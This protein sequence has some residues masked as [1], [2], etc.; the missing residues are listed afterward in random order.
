M[1]RLARNL[2]HSRVKTPGMA[3]LLAATVASIALLQGCSGGSNAHYVPSTTSNPAPGVTLQAVTVAPAVSLISIGESRQLTAIATYSDGTTADVTSTVKWAS[4]STPAIAVSS[5]GMANATTFGSAAVSATLGSS[6]GL[7]QLNVVSNGF[8]S[9]TLAILPVPYKSGLIDA[10]YLPQSLNKIQGT[11]SVQ[12]VNLDADQFS[13]VLPVPS[14]LLASIP[15][16]SGFVPNITVASLTSALV[17]V[18]SYSSPE[19]LIIDASNNAAD[20]AN[21]SVIS[22]FKAPVSGSVTFNGLTCMI[23]AA[24]VN[25]LDNQLLMST[26]DGYFEMDLK[27]GTF[28]A[29]PFAG[30]L[31]SPSFTLNPLSTPP[32]I[33]SSTFGQ[34]PPSPPEV[35]ILD[36]ATN[37]VTSLTN[38]GVTQP[39]ATPIDL[40]V[41]ATAVM[42][43]GAADQSLLDLSNL[44]N[45]VSVL[46]TPLGS[47][48]APGPMGMGA[49][50][51]PPPTAPAFTLFMGQVS[52]SCFGFEEWTGDPTNSLNVQYGY[53]VMPATPDNKP[54]VNGS[55]P[56]TIATFNSV[57]DKKNY[58]V[59]VDANQNWIAKLNPL[60]ATGIGATLGFLP[61]G[62]LITSQDFGQ[63]ASQSIIY[64]PT[65]ASVVTLSQTNIN[66]GTQ[67]VG[68]QSAV[69][70]ITLTNVGLNPLIISQIAVEGA[71]AG[72]FAESDT[73]TANPTLSPLTNCTIQLIF[74][75]S[76]GGPRSATLS[77]TDNGGASPQV[78]LL[79]G[80]GM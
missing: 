62:S 33:V 55:D 29:L 60:V 59:L 79:S 66:F 39:Y 30:A 21:N 43:V 76:G 12:E 28:T 51:V 80:T 20:F 73:C 9:N 26:A 37:G 48:T 56:N 24:I 3:L 69:N 65:P 71:N 57:K 44:Q 1:Q 42:D 78:V 23:C 49:L 19:V 17:A 16:P 7:I 15:M 45:P 31:P 14:A 70:L 68:T 34:N 75:P 10:A 46:A 61:S 25:P 32:Y 22:T 36:L 67:A 53:W 38:L 64:L 5:S 52:G 40:S 54:F 63:G 72:D 74:T 2:F 35:Q 11:F 41:N 27:A 4:T 13:S 8:S 47:C 50:G 58:G 18:I 77:I 6:V